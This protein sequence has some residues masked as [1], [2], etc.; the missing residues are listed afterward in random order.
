MAVPQITS[1]DEFL[2]LVVT[3]RLLTAEELTEPDLSRALADC[4]NAKAVARLLYE[5]KKLSR[6]QAERLMAGRTRGYFIDHY[7]VLEILGFGGMGRIYVAEDTRNGARVALKVLTE[8]HEIDPGMMARLQ[9]EAQAGLRLNH[10]NVVR[11]F[12]TGDTGAVFYVVMECVEGI[13]LH[14]VVARFGPLR[15]RH[16]CDVI[17]QAAAGLHHAHE[18]GL[19]HRDV[20]PANLLVAT[21]GQV[22]ILDFGLALVHGEDDAEFSLQMIFG[23]D[24]LG[25]ADYIAPEQSLNSAEVD[26]RADIYSLGCTLY[27]ALVGSVP[28]PLRTAGEKLRAQRN[29]LP[30]PIEELVPDIAPEVR[31]ILNRMLAKRPDERFS[32]AAEVSELLLALG[33]R[34]PV[35]FNFQRIIAAR[36]R[37]A[38]KRAALQRQQRGSSVTDQSSVTGGPLTGSSLITDRLPGSTNQIQQEFDTAVVGDE[39][40]PPLPAADSGQTPILPSNPDDLVTPT[41]RAA[42]S[43]L[44]G[45]TKAYLVPEQGGPLIE[46]NQ[47]VMMLG[48]AAV[49]QIPFDRPGVSAKHCKFRSEGNWWELADLGSKNGTQ[50]NG[51]DI[52]SRML[53]PGD[54]ISIG[55]NHHFRILESVPDAAQT[56]WTR[57]LA[58]VA[59][60]TAAVIVWWL[61]R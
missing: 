17:G 32:S 35:P 9:L 48:R 26:A 14:E 23:H 40:G 60:I 61:V 38:R 37:V 7:K 1:A 55:R 42:R 10:A 15:W 44:A 5:R 29:A 46:L 3:S 39:H 21:D 16:A 6:Y 54:R 12:E 30:R 25:T 47:P 36:A 53:L 19:V 41:M 34:T 8:R 57:Q 22:K 50:V 56:P 20:K 33:R 28:F 27:F 59:V 18:R 24:C 43:S 11:T 49:C 52:K 51:I 2:E 45:F 4:E 31:K 58:I 13:S